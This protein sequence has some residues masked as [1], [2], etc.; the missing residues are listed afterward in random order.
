MIFHF[1]NDFSQKIINIL[2]RL[3]MHDYKEIMRKGVFSY[4]ECVNC[5]KR[6]YFNIYGSGYSAIDREWLNES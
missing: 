5:K 1:I 4:C 2:C 3:D 6:K